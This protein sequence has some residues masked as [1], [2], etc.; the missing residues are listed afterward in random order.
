MIRCSN[1]GTVTDVLSVFCPKCKQKYTL[2]KEIAESLL[3]EA[4]VALNAKNQLRA[5]EIYKTLADLG[6]LPSIVEY[7]SSLERGD[8]VK[9]DL[10]GAMGYF[11]RGALMGDATSAY[12]YSRLAERTN[13]LVAA[14]WLT[15]GAV[16]G[17]LSAYP[18]LASRLSDMGKDALA[19]YFYRK[20]ADTGHT[21]SIITLAHRYYEGI[22]CEASAPHAKW[23]LDRFSIPPIHALKLSYKLRSVKAEEPPEAV[24]D[25]YPDLIRALVRQAVSLNY[26]T[27]AFTLTGMLYEL[28]EADAERDL[29]LMY[30]HGNGIDRNI[31]RALELLNAS[32]GRGYTDAAMTL[33]DLYAS[34]EL[35]P[36][37][38]EEA[39][40][41]YS[42]AQG[43]GRAGALER[44]GDIYREGRL[45][46]RDIPR[47][48]ELYSEAS[49]IVLASAEEKA[50]AIRADRESL[51][52]KG[53]GLTASSPEEAFRCLAIS[54]G[55]GYP[56][57]YTALADCYLRGVGT[58][59][60]R[61]SAFGWYSEAAK[62]LDRDAT[63]MLGVCY[64]DGI[65][66]D[67]NPIKARQALTRAAS[68][69]VKEAE[70]KLRTLLEAK[71]KKLLR[72]AYALACEHLY[73]RRFDLGFSA[74]EIPARLKYPPALY[75]LGC[76]CEFGLGRPADRDRAYA[77]YE[78][79]FS[80]GFRDPR[81]QYKL[82]IL[83][84]TKS[85]RTV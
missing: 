48:L 68:M 25:G 49:S 45:I 76:L 36:P 72:R 31:H 78:E 10:D 40:K 18:A 2:T 84:L 42:M 53:M 28:G 50:R 8:I 61:A 15:F 33:G 30:L 29:G 82:M 46:R 47:A 83:R 70:D 32:A 63:Y 26:P 64:A 60:D 58:A 54:T 6:H 74:L 59:I 71:K 35:V 67:R 38:A 16:R 73:N 21:E 44:M 80:R 55:M 23:F 34:G 41:Y 81:A 57:A 13:E 9:R 19:N 51:Y 12:R 43:N 62:L 75:T 14:F 52:R 56:P 3:A 1:C 17:C 27:A 69:G 24:I 39:I 22:G 7:G 85:T 4:D 79:A 66:V 37:S 11:S 77:L 65:G 5:L 20:L